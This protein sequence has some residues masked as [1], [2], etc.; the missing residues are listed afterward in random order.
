MHEVRYFKIL[1]VSFGLL[2]ETLWENTH[3]APLSP[4]SFEILSPTCLAAALGEITATSLQSDKVDPSVQHLLAS[5]RRHNYARSANNYHE[6][7]RDRP[8]YC[9]CTMECLWCLFLDIKHDP[10]MLVF[11]DIYSLHRALWDTQTCT[12]RYQQYC[13]RFRTRD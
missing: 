13:W 10:P 12:F 3:V 11:L 2:A 6:R 1:T 4:R 8:S 5:R 9:C 7:V